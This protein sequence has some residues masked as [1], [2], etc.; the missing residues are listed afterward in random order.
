MDVQSLSVV[1]T[2]AKQSPYVLYA[3]W[4]EPLLF[5]ETREAAEKQLNDLHKWLELNHSAHFW[6]FETTAIYDLRTRKVKEANECT[7][8]STQA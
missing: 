8:E 2:L 1:H 3:N 6:G 4:N 7:S 5:F